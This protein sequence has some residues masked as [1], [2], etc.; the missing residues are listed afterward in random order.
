[1]FLIMACLTFLGCEKE[2]KRLNTTELL[3]T[4]QLIEADSDLTDGKTP[5]MTEIYNITF[6][7]DSTFT[8][9]R[10]ESCKKGTFSVIDDQRLLFK[11][12][13]PEKQNLLGNG[14]QIEIFKFN[15]GYL[16]LTPTYLNCIEGCNSK[17]RK[18]SD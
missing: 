18:I 6:N 5:A 12:D 4:W 11:Y 17:F 16:Y 14:E 10:Y 15:D 9:G 2:A 8:S 7:S 13:C 1:M 3:G